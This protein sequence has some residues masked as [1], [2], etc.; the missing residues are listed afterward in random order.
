MPEFT[1]NTPDLHSS[2]NTAAPL[3]ESSWRGSLGRRFRGLG[4]ALERLRQKTGDVFK[5]SGPPAREPAQH[6]PSAEPLAQ[7]QSVRRGP[8]AE[9]RTPRLFPQGAPNPLRSHPVAPTYTPPGTGPEPWGLG[10]ESARSSVAIFDSEATTLLGTG[11]R[12]DTGYTRSTPS[13]SVSS[14]VPSDVESPRSVD[15]SHLRLSAV[16]GA[17]TFGAHAAELTNALSALGAGGSRPG[18]AQASEQS[19]GAYYNTGLLDDYFRGAPEKALPPENPASQGQ[20]A[21]R[22][23]TF[24]MK[25]EVAL[26]TGPASGLQQPGEPQQR[27]P[28]GSIDLQHN[29]SPAHGPAKTQSV[30][31]S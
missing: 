26:P 24:G 16:G 30:G 13:S 19:D 11:S 3:D 4:A 28:R 15:T 21:Q 2:E 6:Q 23:N 20:S 17:G 29:G 8:S 10:L 18:S 1:K 7:Y 9:S 14:L 31:S 5:R 12:A 27:V 25:R 22:R